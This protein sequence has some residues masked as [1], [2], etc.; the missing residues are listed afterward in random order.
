MIKGLLNPLRFKNISGGFYIKLFFIGIIA[1]AY[2]SYADPK[3]NA[4]EYSHR[5]SKENSYHRT[6]RIFRDFFERDYNE[7]YDNEF[8][9]KLLCQ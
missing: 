7:R 8:I 4:K 5:I 2:N 9:K 3:K 1:C 6:Q